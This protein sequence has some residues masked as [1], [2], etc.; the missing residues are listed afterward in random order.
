MR[1]SH[2][3]F[4][5]VLIMTSCLAV[6]RMHIGEDFWLLQRIMTRKLKNN[7]RKE[8]KLLCD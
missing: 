2:K 6:L 4:I 8:L 1:T 3:R 7:K 5:C